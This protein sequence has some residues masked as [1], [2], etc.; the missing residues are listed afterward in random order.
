MLYEIAVTPDVFDATLVDDQTTRG[1]ELRELLRELVPGGVIADLDKG[2]WSKCVQERANGW[3]PALRSALVT[4]LTELD[5]MNRLVRHPQR[6]C[7]HPD[8]DDQWLDLALESHHRCA[9]NWIVTNE[10]MI[11][12]LR[13]DEDIIDVSSLRNSPEWSERRWSRSVRMCEQ[14]YLVMIRP[15][16]RYAKRLELVDRYL[17]PRDWRHS[18]FIELCAM[19]LGQGGNAVHPPQ[20]HLHTW[21]EASI[22]EASIDASL[23]DWMNYLS[24]IKAKHRVPH[25]FRVFVWGRKENGPSM[26]DRFLLTDQCGVTVGW[27]F[28]CCD[29]ETTR[30]TTWTLLDKQTWK[31]RR[32]DFVPD[33]GPYQYL[34]DRTLR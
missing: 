25:L 13:M 23:T 14:E 2:Y 27:G 28:D 15:L 18:R 16:L 10:N 21:M 3:S 5:K 29:N 9:F 32:N 7:G 4:H 19:A 11:E 1:F 31:V 33:V 26:H 8:S 12:N 30:E 17:S 24:R 34:D 6:R 20:I 22:S